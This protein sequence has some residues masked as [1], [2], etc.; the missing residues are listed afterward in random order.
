[1][2][3]KVP[4]ISGPHRK[5][6][7]KE[8][9]LGWSQG[10]QRASPTGSGLTISFARSGPSRSATRSRITSSDIGVIRHG[11]SRGDDGGSETIGPFW[12][13]EGG[14]FPTS[15]CRF[16][17][18]RGKGLTPNGYP[19]T[20][21]EQSWWLATRGR[22]RENGHVCCKW[23]PFQN[24]SRNLFPPRRFSPPGDSAAFNGTA[25][26][27][28]PVNGYLTFTTPQPA[29]RAVVRCRQVRRWGQTK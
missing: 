8:Q 21:S 12:Q 2:I 26:Q 5:E 27:P 9:A 11:G 28:S 14:G 7:P 6:S 22:F 25:R 16:S 3:R 4:S 24:L 13:E 29:L 20:R 10:L 23:Q 17:N 1:M 19:E 15:A 18:S